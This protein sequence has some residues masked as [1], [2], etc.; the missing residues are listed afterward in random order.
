M[1]VVQSPAIEVTLRQAL[2]GDAAALRIIVDMLTP[3]VQARVARALLRTPQGTFGRNV[4]QEVEDLTQDV[5]IALFKKNAQTL[6]RWQP[7]RGCSLKNFVGLIAQREVISILRSRKR[8][9]WAESPTETDTLEA[10]ASV[11]RN[12]PESNVASR[13]LWARL[14]ERVRQQLSPQGLVLFHRLLVE[15]CPMNRLA[16]E[17]GMSVNAL[18]TWRSRLSK[19]VKVLWDELSSEPPAHP[20][21]TSDRLKTSNKLRTSHRLKTPKQAKQVRI[22]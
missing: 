9:P 7:Q 8:S 16:T 3:V 19:Q 10:L 20:A 17:T 4:H 5:F 1:T 14:L 2:G 18:Y 6:R 13:E 22:Q 21:P 11:E 15:Q 12:T